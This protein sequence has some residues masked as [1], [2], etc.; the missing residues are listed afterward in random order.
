MFSFNNPTG[1]C[2]D[3]SGLGT[4]VIMSENLLVPD[5][6]QSILG[7]AVEPLGDVP[8]ADLLAEQRGRDEARQRPRG[9]PGEKS[10]Q[11]SVA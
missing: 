2:P 10:K 1:M 3:C 8:D 7:G 5:P 6:S 11:P 4:R 9:A